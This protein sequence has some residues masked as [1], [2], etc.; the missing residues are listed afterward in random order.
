[1]SQQGGR[2]EGRGLSF[3]QLNCRGS[4]AAWILSQ[5]E[6]LSCG[7]PPPDV[8]LLQDL[9]TSVRAG[10]LG[11]VGYRMILARSRT[12]EL[13][14]VG[15]MVRDTLVA[16]EIRPFGHRVVGVELRGLHG[17]LRVFS[18]YVRHTTG[19]GVEQLTLALRW[20]LSKG[21]RVV[22][23]LDSN[24]HNALWGPPTT[25]LNQVGAQVEDMIL[26]LGL[27]VVNDPDSPPTF[28]SGGHESWIDLTLASPTAAVDMGDWH[29]D[30]HF[31]S[32][33]DH[34]PLRFIFQPGF[35]EC[36][37]PKRKAWREVDWTR[38]GQ[39]VESELHNR[40]LLEERLEGDESDQSIEVQVLHITA[41]FQGA[42]A[43]TVR[44]KRVRA[45]AKPWWTPALNDL[46]L[47]C[48]RLWRRA[49]RLQTEPAFGAYRV[50]RRAFV[51]A[52][53]Q[54]KALAWRKF[55]EGLTLH[56]VWPSLQRFTK[57]RHRLHVED[58][59]G[60]EDT[61][62]EEDSAK[63]QLLAQRFFPS[64]PPSANFRQL[65]ASR[66]DTLQTWLAPG[67]TGF[68]P[69]TASEVSR[70]L[71]HLRAFAAPG[72]DGILPQCL[73]AAEPVLVPVLTRLFNQLLREGRHPTP[74]R[75]A[76][77]LPIP[78]P[79]SDAHLPKG[80][81]PIALLNTLSKLMESIMNGRLLHFLERTHSL[82]DA[83]QGFRPT[84]STE[85]ALWRFVNSAAMDLKSRRRCI[86]VALDIQS[87]YD[88]VDHAA[89]LWRLMDKDV[90]RYMV[91]WVQGFLT[92]RSVHLAVNRLETTIAVGIGVP[93]GSPISPTL[94]IVFIDDLVRALGTMVAVQAYADDLLL[95]CSLPDGTTAPLALQAALDFVTKWGQQWGLTFNPVKCQALDMHHLGHC[96]PIQLT[97]DG[98]HLTFV[99]E[100]KYLGVWI[101][102]TLS[103]QRH[104]AEVYKSCMGR[105]R[106]LRRMAAT[107]WGLHPTVM[108]HLVK[109]TIF[110]C[111]LSGVTAWGDL[112]RFQTRLAP[113]DRVLRHAAILTLG[114]LSSTSGVRAAAACGWLPAEFLI[115]EALMRFLVRQT[116]YGRTDLLLGPPDPGF[117]RRISTIDIVNQE[118]RSFSRACP[119]DAAAWSHIDRVRLWVRPPWDCPPPLDCYFPPR[120]QAAELLEQAMQSPGSTWVFTDGSVI[121]SLS[122]AGV[123]FHGAHPP[124]AQEVGVF[125]GPAQ[126][127]TDAEI[128]GLHL[129]ISHL[130]T[131][132]GWDHATI[133]TD[134]SSAL[135][136]L[137]ADHWK[138]DR[139]SLCLLRD[140]VRAL[141]AQGL[142]ISFWWV[143]G[144]YKIAGNEAADR[145]ARA[146]A[147]AGAP[148][149]E[150]WIS[151]Y[152]M[153]RVLRQWYERRVQAQEH[154]S[155]G[156]MLDITED[157]IVHTDLRWTRTIPTRRAVALVAQFITGHFPTA[158]YL[159]VRGL[160]H[161]PLCDYCG[162]LDT[163]A[164]LLLE[165]GKYHH[166]RQHL[167]SWLLSVASARLP[168]ATSWSWS[169][170]F[171][172]G[173]NAGRCWLS[174]FLARVHSIQ[175]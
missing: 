25:I 175:N 68:P 28:A 70:H 59:C 29:V 154:S 46:R 3:F 66:Q 42:I 87:A 36:E 114:L 111:M 52:V 124:G 142:A 38:F 60:P 127:S 35:E 14:E 143:P 117:N 22:V 12:Q 110:P 138:R 27:E 62:V 157:A 77:V 90:P 91:A 9:P 8:I 15:I 81:R 139:E 51:T 45:S 94:F 58:L 56:D 140:S 103:W 69:I 174:R 48:R 96:Q 1:M 116:S 18:A 166:H 98:S 160:H 86:S 73:R 5:R 170:P 89:L 148:Q 54:A 61:W 21:P 50:A 105:L 78:K 106:V 131:R 41:A 102:R 44:E 129:A 135:L 43:S 6:I 74:W 4:E 82:S 137:V 121:G 152:M 113:L 32:G 171:L 122:G 93:Q 72:P 104:I 2:G 26:A 19:E 53:R 99:K 23:G 162:C 47:Q 151:P 11:F 144:H 101:D 63:A 109:A 13:P 49:Q 95:W 65:T 10:G 31:Y 79:G 150:F 156:T 107:Y 165:C 120:E 172:V 57:P 126:A 132:P 130:A 20:A 55:C 134:S 173:T 167:T 30:T 141:S 97:L 161:S 85:L 169:W 76:R 147:Q 115:R 146:S 34:R 155:M 84:R 64:A 16:K 24:G 149:G 7:G 80:Y 37:P 153:G 108:A 75:L 159:A 67:W 119:C 163:R 100:L 17:P 158:V 125:L 118:M 40:G 92:S 71:L 128:S 112:V 133:V 145:V 123:V 164:H 83:Q 168:P 39:E 88:S 33:S 136:M